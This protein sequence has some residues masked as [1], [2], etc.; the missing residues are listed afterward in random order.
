MWAGFFW[1]PK[2]HRRLPLWSINRCVAR[3][4]FTRPVLNGLL[5]ISAAALLFL[6]IF[7]TDYWVHL[8]AASLVFL[9]AAFAVD[10]WRACY[11]HYWFM[12]LAALLLSDPVTSLVII[13]GSLYLW[14]GFFKLTSPLF[15]SNTSLFTFKRV[16]SALRVVPGSMLQLML[17]AAAVATEMAMGAVFLAHEYL[18]VKL[19]YTFACF[20]FLM[21]FYIVVFI[22][23]DNGIHTFVPWNAMCVALSALL[24]GQHN[25]QSSLGLQLHHVILIVALHTPPILQIFGK[26][27][28]ATLSHSWFV[29][30]ASGCCFLLVP[31]TIS[32]NVPD[33]DNNMPIRRLREAGIRFEAI[34][35][36]SAVQADA[37][38]LFGDHAFAGAVNAR[39]LVQQCIL[40]DDNWV[41]ASLTSCFCFSR[42]IPGGHMLPTPH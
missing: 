30:S 33:S 3:F 27:E 1:I 6:S 5:S 15:H 18:P 7:F 39:Q 26:N 35:H 11:L 40:I 16:F 42:G 32:S 29:P 24:F 19:L 25:A 8:V 20:N 38:L 28:Y 31:P 34:S 2:M 9:A 21:H 36:L 14:A 12:A 37:K 17:S 4:F 23:I 41:R 10:L 13:L 22:G